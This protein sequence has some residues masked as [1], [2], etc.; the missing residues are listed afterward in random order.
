MSEPFLKMNKILHK[1][2]E[3]VPEID[4]SIFDKQEYSNFKEGN[5]LFI[6]NEGLAKQ[7]EERYVRFPL[8]EEFNILYFSLEG[9]S[10]LH[11]I[12]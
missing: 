7:V 8:E 2:G 9:I 6:T 11:T 4:F 5:W 10:D 3:P 1:K 12:D